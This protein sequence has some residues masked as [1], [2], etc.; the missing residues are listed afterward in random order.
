MS[1]DQLPDD[2]EPLT[3]EDLAATAYKL[4][5]YGNPIIDPPLSCGCHGVTYCERHRLWKAD[6]KRRSEILKL[7]DMLRVGGPT[8]DKP[9]GS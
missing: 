8:W 5:D 7:R 6:I 1:D 4:D 3:D 9:M 2:H